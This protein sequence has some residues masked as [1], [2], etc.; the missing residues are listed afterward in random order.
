MLELHGNTRA[1]KFCVSAH[2]MEMGKF[3][4][5]EINAPK[6]YKLEFYYKYA[7]VSCLKLK[8]QLLKI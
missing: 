5:C 6:D 7:V 8:V 2:T 1:S 3:L 4:V